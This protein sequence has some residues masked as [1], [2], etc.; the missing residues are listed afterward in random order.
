MADGQFGHFSLAS[1]MITRQKTYD[2][3][4]LKVEASPDNNSTIMLLY[5]TGDG[6]SITSDDGLGAQYAA[7]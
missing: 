4:G 7:E 6:I 2:A 1:W 3:Y 5:V